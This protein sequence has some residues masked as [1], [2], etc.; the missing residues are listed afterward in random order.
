MSHLPIWFIGS[1]EPKMC[2]RVVD[3]MLVFDAK[4]ATLGPGG[5]QTNNLTR[6]TDIRFAPSDYWLNE[7]FKSVANQAN[8]VCAWNY[9]VTSNESIQFA[10]YGVNQHYTWHVDTFTLSGAPE[11][12]KITIVCLLNDEFKGGDFEVRL[13]NDYKA[14]LQ[15]GSIIAFP[16]ILEH[17][18]TPI[19]EGV[20]YSATMWLSGPRFR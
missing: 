11:D 16:S 9:L 6:N 5:D 10:S 14:P 2:D 19:V 8:T 1:I 13:Y 4:E 12:R 15:K 3:E 7:T 20:R 17:R 18:V